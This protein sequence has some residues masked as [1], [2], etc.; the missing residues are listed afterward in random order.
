MVM[1]LILLEFVCGLACG[2]YRNRKIPH[3]IDVKT[4]EEEVG[5]VFEIGVRR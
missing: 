2:A 4:V 5:K 1:P 3:F